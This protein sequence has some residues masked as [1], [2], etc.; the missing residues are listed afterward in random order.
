MVDIDKYLYYDYRDSVF[1]HT[2]LWTYKPL[3][4]I[5]ILKSVWEKKVGINQMENE[6]RS[7]RFIY[8]F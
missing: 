1:I 6:F 4:F 5:S 8:L 7:E 2:F 3:L